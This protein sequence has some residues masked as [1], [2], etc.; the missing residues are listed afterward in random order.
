MNPTL[1]G[2]N[3]AHVNLMTEAPHQPR[4]PGRQQEHARSSSIEIDARPSSFYA[5]GP[6][7]IHESR[8]VRSDSSSVN[9]SNG[10]GHG[11]SS[12]ISQ[13]YK[14]FGGFGGGSSSPAAVTSFNDAAHNPSAGANAASQYAPTSAA[15]RRGAAPAPPVI[16]SPSNFRV[17]ENPSNP[18]ANPSSP[19][20]PYSRAGGSS[21]FLQS[22][23]RG[24]RAGQL[25]S[26]FDDRHAVRVH[27]KPFAAADISGELIFRYI[28]PS[29]R[30]LYVP[31]ADHLLDYPSC[32][33]RPSRELDWLLS[34]IPLA[35]HSKHPSAFILASSFLPFPR[36]LPQPTKLL[37]S[38]PTLQLLLPA[39]RSNR[40]TPVQ[41][42]PTRSFCSSFSLFLP[43]S[44]PFFPFDGRLHPSLASPFFPMHFFSTLSSIPSRFR[45]LP[46]ST[47]PLA[48]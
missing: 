35:T 12:R 7:S 46:L 17:M 33:P 19:A 27:R 40:P 3:L 41:T 11:S 10:H 20:V 36:P 37:S 1:S 25:E 6:P 42:A 39:F 16:G 15:R 43:L 47:R 31:K 18:F 2:R 38:C 26:P 24:G 5:F 44:S 21:P 9:G 14:V 45:L 8:S 32:R 13:L 30:L 48:S 34:Q 4:S 28:F 23:G 22:G 29:L